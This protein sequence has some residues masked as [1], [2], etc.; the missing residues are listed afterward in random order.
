MT[1]DEMREVQQLWFT[2][3]AYL[4]MAGPLAAETKSYGQVWEAFKKDPEQEST[5]RTVLLSAHLNSA[6][7]RFASLEE[8]LVG[9]DQQLRLLAYPKAKDGAFAGSFKSRYIHVFLRDSLS[10]AEPK[11]L[12]GER[13]EWKKRQE[14][15]DR[16]LVADT[17]QSMG[18]LAS[19][20]AGEIANR[21]AALTSLKTWTKMKASELIV[22]LVKP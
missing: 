9:G 1:A 11:G 5:L 21:H 10:H 3:S 8:F 6:A 4:H 17:Y 7:G 14:W 22:R 19:I 13:P 18:M 12:A 20:L 16:C 15:L 2:G